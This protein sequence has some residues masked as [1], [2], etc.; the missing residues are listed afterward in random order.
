MPSA[1]TDEHI[2]LMASQEFLWLISWSTPPQANNVVVW[3]LPAKVTNAEVTKA[4]STLLLRYEALRT[5]FGLTDAGLPYQKVATTTPHSIPEYDLSADPQIAFEVTSEVSASV[6]Q[7]HGCP[8]YHVAILADREMRWLVLAV[9]HL[10]ADGESMDVL[11]RAFYQILLGEAPLDAGRQP[12]EQAL[13]ETSPAYRRRLDR[14]L[15]GF[16]EAV[17]QAPARLFPLM[18]HEV[19][20]GTCLLAR[21]RSAAVDSAARGL[22]A[23]LGVTTPAI[24][25]TV[26]VACLTTLSRNPHYAIYV[27]F[28]GRFDAAMEGSVGCYFTRGLVAG[29]TGDGVSFLALTRSIQEQ[30]LRA[31]E[32]SIYSHCEAEEARVRVE[33]A[34]GRLLP[35]ASTFD[36]AEASPEGPPRDETACDE[37]SVEETEHPIPNNELSIM[38]RA[39][40]GTAELELLGSAAA[41]TGDELASAVRAMGQV[42]VALSEDPGALDADIGKLLRRHGMPQQAYGPDVVYSDA[43]WINLAATRELVASHEYVRDACV[44]ASGDSTLVAYVVAKSPELRPWQL[45]RHML[46]QLHAHPGAAVPHRFSVVDAS[47]PSGERDAT[48]W[49]RQTV[50]E[51]GDGRWSPRREPASLKEHAISSAIRRF[52]PGIEVDV[53]TDYVSLGGHALLAPA[54]ARTVEGSG[55]AGLTALDLLQPCS[56]AALARRLS[57]R[58]LPPK[59]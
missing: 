59:W 28:R 53:N 18:R 20:P 14:A 12:A 15:A 47:P 19:P 11:R 21:L 45:R 46:D 10:V 42:I 6:I 41:L 52:H 30:T 2:P 48:A 55:Y 5:T 26:F 40:A 38:V 27:N 31:M 34:R 35:L 7:P 1:R 51:E 3:D 54:V 58:R 43:T 37:V 22:A 33:R 44:V 49:E 50:V 57:P 17:R 56:I 24:Y 39:G 29:S 9:S 13:L 32:S 16:E 25:S 8:L 4:F 36:Y 23:R